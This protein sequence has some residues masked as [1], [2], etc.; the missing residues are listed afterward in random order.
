VLRKASVIEVITDLE[1]SN[2]LAYFSGRQISLSVLRKA[3]LFPPSI[4]NHYY[5]IAEEN[6]IFTIAC[7]KKPKNF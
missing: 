4:E 7:R 6:G 5:Y 2:I 3:G 1:L